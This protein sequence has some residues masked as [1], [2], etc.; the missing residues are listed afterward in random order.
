MSEVNPE[1][2][3]IRGLPGS[4]KSTKAKRDFPDH[5]HYEPDHLF[6]DTQGRYR[7]DMQLFTEAKDFVCYLADFALARGENVVVTDVLPKLDELRPFYQ[8]ADAH[9]ATIKVIDCEGD[10]NNCHRVPV[11]VLQKMWDEFEPYEVQGDDRLKVR[12]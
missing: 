9:N 1:L 3:I 4:G 5:L 2:V 12:F 7:F 6:S 8:I 10:F 11:M